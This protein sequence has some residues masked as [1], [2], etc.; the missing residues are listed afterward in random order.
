[1]QVNGIILIRHKKTLLYVQIG[2]FFRFKKVM[3]SDA[4][5]APQKKEMGYWC[6]IFGPISI[7]SPIQVDF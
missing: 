2:L 1:M 4:S 7:P 6:L 3:M 5:D